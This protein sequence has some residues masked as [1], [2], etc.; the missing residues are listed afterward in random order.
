MQSYDGTADLETME[1]LNSLI[2]SGDFEVHIARIFPL[3]QAA[4]AHRALEQHYLGKLAL[5]AE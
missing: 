4:E 5:K 3:G 2:E 1:T